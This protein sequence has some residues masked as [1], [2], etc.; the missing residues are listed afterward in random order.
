[1]SVLTFAG[2]G[3]EAGYGPNKGV[4]A[5]PGGN[6]SGPFMPQAARPNMI[7]TAAIRDIGG[8]LSAKS[9]ML[10]HHG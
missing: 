9:G 7:N 1:M 5:G 3:L 2:T 8:M 10:A 6:S 4:G